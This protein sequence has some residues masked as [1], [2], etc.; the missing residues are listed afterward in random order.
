MFGMLHLPPDCNDNDLLACCWQA[1][2][3]AAAN[4]TALAALGLTMAAVGDVPQ[5]S[6][7]DKVALAGAAEFATQVCTTTLNSEEV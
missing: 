6:E 3:D 7:K 4:P 2:V 5:G 1:M